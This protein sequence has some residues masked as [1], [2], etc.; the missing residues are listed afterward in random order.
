MH[1]FILGTVVVLLIGLIPVVIGIYSAPEGYED[2]NGFH[3]GRPK[4]VVPPARAAVV[5]RRAG[6][7]EV[8]W[9]G[10]DGENWTTNQENAGDWSDAEADE[11]AYRHGN[12]AIALP[13]T[14]R[15]LRVEPSRA[16][17]RVGLGAIARRAIPATNQSAI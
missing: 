12:G 3:Q 15:K 5:L 1:L 14:R 10:P 13:R 7:F 17:A 8:Q 9:L 11:L 2:E 6:D 16:S 4:I